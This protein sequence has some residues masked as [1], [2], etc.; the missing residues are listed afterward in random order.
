[1]IAPVDALLVHH[2]TLPSRPPDEAFVARVE[3]ALAAERAR[4]TSRR[5]ARRR[6][7]VEAGAATACVGAAAL[8]GRAGDPA[9]LFDAIQSGGAAVTALALAVFWLAASAA[10]KEEL[11]P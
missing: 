2:L 3:L 4:A 8:I 5:A 11:L 6:L 7:L 1:M 9:V 10:A